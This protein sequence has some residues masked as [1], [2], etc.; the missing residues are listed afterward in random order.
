MKKSKKVQS[1]IFPLPTMTSNKWWEKNQ[2][3]EALTQGGAI[4]T[5]QQCSCNGNGG[6]GGNGTCGTGK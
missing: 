4:A 1:G 5:Q 3:S 2:S 6:G